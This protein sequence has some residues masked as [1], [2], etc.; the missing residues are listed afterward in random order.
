MKYFISTDLE[1][2]RELN[3]RGIPAQNLSKERFNLLQHPERAEYALEIPEE[4]TQRFWNLLTREEFLAIHAAL[5]TPEMLQNQGWFPDALN[6][7]IPDYRV[8]S[9][10]A[11]AS[12]IIKARFSLEQQLNML[13]RYSELCGRLIILPYTAEAEEKA[14]LEAAYDWIKAVRAESNR[15]EADPTAVPNW[16]V[17]V[18]P[19]ANEGEG[20]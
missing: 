4:Y 7:D 17:W 16:P 3:S 20:A 10:K 2:L 1:K 14:R 11:M 18:A 5:R 6:P 19:G 9:I 15:L 13:A 12:N 8:A